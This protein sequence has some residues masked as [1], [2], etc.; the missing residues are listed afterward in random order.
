MS[1]T[2]SVQVTKTLCNFMFGQWWK[3]CWKYKKLYVPNE[4]NLMIKC[5]VCWVMTIPYNIRTALIQDIDSLDTPSYYTNLLTGCTTESSESASLESQ[6]P[7]GRTRECKQLQ[8][9]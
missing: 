5:Y 9:T 3:L 8:N 4:A 2:K 1:E 7:G 6:T